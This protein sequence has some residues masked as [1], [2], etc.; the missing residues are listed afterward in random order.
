[1][2]G[3]DGYRLSMC[4]VFSQKWTTAGSLAHSD[5]LA[6]V[7]ESVEYP[8]ICLEIDS[9]KRAEQSWVSPENTAC[10]LNCL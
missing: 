4:R 8:P 2:A 3:D 6:V 1:M 10:E 9:F 5:L 7:F